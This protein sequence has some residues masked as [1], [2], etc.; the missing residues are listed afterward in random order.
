MIGQSKRLSIADI[1][2]S[3]KGN[4][5]TLI[6]YLTFVI[7]YDYHFQKIFTDLLDIPFSKFNTLDYSINGYSKCYVYNNIII[8]TDG[9]NKDGI[10]YSMGHL[11]LL[12][13]QGCRYYEQIHGNVWFTL[14]Q[15]ILDLEGHFTRIDLAID[16][17]EGYFTIDQLR[18]DYIKYGLI[19]SK[20]QF[21]QS[22]EKDRFRDGETIGR[23]YYLG[24]NTGL[25]QVYFY[26]KHWERLTDEELAIKNNFDLTF[27]QRTE[28]RL[29]KEKAQKTI[30]H[31][32]TY[33]DYYKFGYMVVEILNKHFRLIEP[34]PNDKNY[35][36]W[37]A[38]AFWS[39]FLGHTNK[40][41]LT[42]KKPDRN[43]DTIRDF[44]DHQASKNVLMLVLSQP[45]QYYQILNKAQKK[46][47]EHDLKIIQDELEKNN[48]KELAI[49]EKRKIIYESNKA[50]QEKFK[51]NQKLRNL[52]LLKNKHKKME[53]IQEELELSPYNFL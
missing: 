10:N 32:L 17:F 7:P 19:I 22:V 14:L 44:V 12:S 9:L 16:D 52:Q 13:G 29:K 49:L 20:M 45:D 42:I 6:D 15:T 25:V 51:L 47:T 5:K 8:A 28:I 50:D 31:L 34:N 26:E 40:A 30:E 18:Q 39:D 46:L 35:R 41:D 27:W 21:G 24:S 48:Q 23:S 53:T 4:I 3:E 36:R 43:I 38:P 37:K 1:D 33:Q 2:Y 11:V